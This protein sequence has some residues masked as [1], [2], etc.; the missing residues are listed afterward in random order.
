[1]L[2]GVYAAFFAYFMSS[3]VFKDALTTSFE[4]ATQ[5]TDYFT[6][7]IIGSALMVLSVAS[8]MNVGRT[9]MGEMREGTFESLMLSPAKRPLYFVGCWLEQIYRS[10]F[11]FFPTLII[12]TLL[13]AQ[14]FNSS[15]ASLFIVYLITIVSLFGLSIC[16][17]AVMIWSRDTYLTQNTLFILMALTCGVLCP[18]ALL[19]EALQWIGSLIPLTYALDIFRAVT[20]QQQ[21]LS[22]QLPAITLCLGLSGVYGLA[23]TVFFRLFERRINERVLN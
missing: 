9:M 22:S 23:G 3:Y 20:M 16:L 13:G 19:P 14:V 5:S 8:L 2:S 6:F 7:A 21:N 10:F 12:G 17:A 11:E 18:R 4:Q 1:M 15:I